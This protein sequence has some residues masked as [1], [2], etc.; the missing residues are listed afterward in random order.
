M[1]I[2]NFSLIAKE[3]KQNMQGLSQTTMLEALGI[4]MAIGIVGAVI[5]RCC[6][7]C[8]NA[9]SQV[10]SEIVADQPG[11]EA[12]GSENGAGQVEVQIDP[13]V[14]GSPYEPYFIPDLGDFLS[15]DIWAA[16]FLLFCHRLKKVWWIVWLFYAPNVLG[17][18]DN[19]MPANPTFIPAH[20][21]LEWYSLSIHAVP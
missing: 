19:Y 8:S 15:W 4:G 3:A 10:A 5:G 2:K 1:I 13:P 14:I 7:R 18:P 17:H 11:L 16:T 20:I 9:N 6:Y 12:S 21:V